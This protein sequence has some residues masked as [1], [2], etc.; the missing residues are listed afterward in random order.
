MTLLHLDPD[1]SHLFRRILST[2][3]YRFCSTPLPL[4]RQTVGSVS[5]R[6]LSLLPLP[7]LSHQTYEASILRR[8]KVRGAQVDRAD[9]D[10]YL[11]RQP[12]THL[13]EQIVIC[14]SLVRRAV[15][16]PRYTQER[17]QPNLLL[18]TEPGQRQPGKVPKWRLFSLLGRPPC[19]S[20]YPK[21]VIGSL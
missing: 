13:P 10:G 5:L 14:Y 9:C 3:I 15:V 2:P 11:G 6:A 20:T 19:L 18:G 1:P 4:N 17:R 8:R 12:L 21:A 16:I 7:P